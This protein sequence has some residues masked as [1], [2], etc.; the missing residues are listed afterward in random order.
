M[1]EIKRDLIWEIKPDSKEEKIYKNLEKQIER[2]FRNCRQ[3]SIKTRIRYKDGAKHFAKFLAVVY[4]KQNMNNI[5]NQSLEA[6][7]E[8]SQESGYSTSYITTNMSAIRFCVNQIKDSRYIKSNKELEVNNRTKE[9]RIGPNRAW[10][11]DQ[12]TKMYRL[13]IGNGYSRVA[14]IITL[15]YRQG[16]RLHEI[17]RLD[18]ATLLD[19]LRK[20]K[21]TIKGKGGLI[22][23]VPIRDDLSRKHIKGLIDKTPVNS[24][25]VFV[26]SNEKTDSVINQVQNF[27]QNYRGGVIDPGGHQITAHGLRHTYAQERYKEL[28]EKGI[29]EKNARLQV[30]KE[31]GHFRPEITDIYL[32][33]KEEENYEQK[34]LEEKQE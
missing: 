25:K 26:S 22:R 8:Q 10:T 23:R 13:A 15:A 12:V 7:V 30:S 17:T 4:K 18:R 34:R 1:R 9:D 14:D 33:S 11:R 2:I 5:S 31:L 6:Y 19:S 24:Y 27:I 29:R 16:L 28:I 21:I 3:G 32:K 20:D